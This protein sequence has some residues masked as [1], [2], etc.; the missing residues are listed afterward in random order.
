VV[1]AVPLSP[2]RQK[3]R[4]YN[5]AERVARP[6]AMRLGVRYNPFVMKRIRDTVSQVGLSGEAR[7]RNVAG[8]FESVPELVA[9]KKVLLFDD[10]MTTGSTLAA[11]SSALNES[12]AQAVYCLTIGR[13]VWRDSISFSNLHPV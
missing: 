3:E 9:G 4:G 10:V 7:R 2:Q 12:G 1:T 13:F 5:Q 8:A 6:L 11:C